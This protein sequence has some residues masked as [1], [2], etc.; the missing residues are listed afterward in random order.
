MEPEVQKIMSYPK[1]SF[2]RKNLLTELRKKGNYI[3]N[4]VKCDKPIKKS[5][6]PVDYLPCEK[7]LGFYS[8]K[9]LWKHEKICQPLSQTANTQV[10]AQNFMLRNLPN[11][12]KKL[13]EE[14]FL[15]M[16]PDKISLQAK[17]DMLICAVWN[18]IF[19]DSSR[20]TLCKRH[21]A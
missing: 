17:R 3:K 9:Q 13:K 12:Y 7:C 14:V 15:K 21:I 5:C 11:I 1:K 4:V 10:H 19:K 16:R 8:R 20:K 6:L 18:P 2:T